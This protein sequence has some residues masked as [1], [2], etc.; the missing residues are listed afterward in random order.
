MSAWAAPGGD[1]FV[2]QGGG[3]YEANVQLPAG[4]SDYKVA[5]G[6]WSFEFADPEK[7]TPLDTE[8]TMVPAPGQGTQGS[9][10]AAAGGCYSF[11]MDA[12]DT[13]APT[14]TVS[15]LE[16]GDPTDVLAIQRDYQNAASV[17]V[18]IN[19]E[20]TEVDLTTLGGGGIPVPFADGAVVEITG[21]DNDLLVSGGLLQGTVPARSSYLVSD[22]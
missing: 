7:P 15:L 22:Q 20:N 18:V 19:N 9:I 10:E 2:N 1:S 11:K 3:A 4:S 21:A 8:V 6:D 5:A 17:V 12:T 13:D 16:I 14:L